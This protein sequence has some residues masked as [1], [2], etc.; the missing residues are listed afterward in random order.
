MYIDDIALVADSV[1]ALPKLIQDINYCREF[2][3][4]WLNNDKCVCYDPSASMDY[5]V[6]D[7]AV[8]SSPVKYLGVFIGISHDLHIRNFEG[9][10]RKMKEKAKH[11]HSRFISLEGSILVAK[12]LLLSCF[13]HI[14]NCTFVS[15][16]QVTVLQNFL[17]DFIWHGRNKVKLSVFSLPYSLGSMKMIN[18]KYF[19][20]KL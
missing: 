9:P 11:W 13:T 20:H 1:H 12:V 17:S 16:D 19:V 15:S 14:M 2:T 10:L 6:A 18:V 7:V 5:L 3:D 4:L 8:M